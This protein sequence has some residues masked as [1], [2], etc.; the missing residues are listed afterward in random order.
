MG[1]KTKTKAVFISLLLIAGVF[2]GHVCEAAFAIPVPSAPGSSTQNNKK[3]VIDY[4]N[5]KDGYVMVKYTQSTKKAVKAIVKGPSGEPYTYVLKV[6]NYEVFPLSEGSGSYTIGI[7]EQV[8]GTKYAVANTATVKVSLSSEFAPFLCPNQYVNYNKDKRTVKKAAELT[9]NGSGGI[10]DM[11]SAVYNYIIENISYDQNL[12]KNVQV[13][14][15]PDVDAVLGKGKGICF[16]YAAVMA[17]ML[18]SV[19]IPCRLV[20]GYSGKAYH[21]WISTYSKETGTVNQVIQFDGKS[22]TLMDPTF[23]SSGKQSDQIMKYIGNGSNYKPK[24]KY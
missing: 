4:S 11:I 13:G 21:A 3:A 14:Y 16:D 10:T 17:S 1:V 22:W 9:N 20:V 23:A 24:F 5:T 15:L 7:Y 19:G 8:E 2:C 12:A 6:G 18:R